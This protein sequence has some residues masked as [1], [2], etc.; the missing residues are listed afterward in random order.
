MVTT[1][2]ASSPM[3][4][5]F[6]LIVGKTPP[7]KAA[8]AVDLVDKKASLC[9]AAA[10]VDQVGDKASLGKAAAVDLVGGNSAPTKAVVRTLS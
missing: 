4:V 2:G 3:D 8:A 1:V 5:A 7:S 10:V 6:E 9:K